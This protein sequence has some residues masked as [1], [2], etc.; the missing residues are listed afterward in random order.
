MANKGANLILVARR[1]EK[2]NQ[3]KEN[4][5]RSN[6]NI[7]VYVFTCDLTSGMILFI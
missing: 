3:V 4:I 2:L 7:Q 6:A 5:L 1:T